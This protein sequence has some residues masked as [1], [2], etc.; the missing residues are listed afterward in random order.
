MLAYAI[1]KKILIVEDDKDMRD[2]IAQKLFLKKFQIIQAEDGEQAIA[3]AIEHKP[4][5]ILL[6]LMLPKMDGFTVLEN[7]RKHPDMSIARVPVI[8][9]SN[10]QAPKDFTAAENLKVIN[11]FVKAQTE[12]ETVCRRVEEI[13]ANIASPQPKE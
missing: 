4:H 1:E 12:I 6:D 10:L 9:L 2:I 11:Y 8:I 13:L 7:L 3:K 5:L